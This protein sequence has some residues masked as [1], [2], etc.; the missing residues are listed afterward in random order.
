M[1]FYDAFFFIFIKFEKNLT[2]NKKSILKKKKKKKK[3]KLKR[4]EFR[5]N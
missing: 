1:L 5:K 4:K 2:L 3:N